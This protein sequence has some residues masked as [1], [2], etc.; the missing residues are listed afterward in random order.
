[1]LTDMQAKSDMLENT[2]EELG[3][4]FDTFSGKLLASNILMEHQEIAN[5]FRQTLETFASLSK[6]VHL[7][8]SNNDSPV[9]VGTLPIEQPVGGSYAQSF[10]SNQ[11]TLLE[12]APSLD[13]TA[14]IMTQRADMLPNLGNW[15]SSAAQKTAPPAPSISLMLIRSPVLADDYWGGELLSDPGLSFS[16]RLHRST[17]LASNQFL[18]QADMNGPKS[19]SMA[20]AHTYSLRRHNPAALLKISS[21]GIRVAAME[22]QYRRYSAPS[23][24]PDPLQSLSGQEPETRAYFNLDFAHDLGLQLRADMISDGMDIQDYIDAKAVEDYLGEKGMVRCDPHYIQ[25]RLDANSTATRSRPSISEPM[26]LSISTPSLL[27]RL[28]QVSLCLGD[29]IGFSKSSINSALVASV[30]KMT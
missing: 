6:K 18:R 14:V 17:M 5:S 23:F 19:S 15:T 4:S 26:L 22:D 13:T 12:A 29:S 10:V 20:R 11:Q 16:H 27:R 30:V 28:M 8:E 7:D 9:L 3:K 2:I 25:M 24:G 1:M 21:V